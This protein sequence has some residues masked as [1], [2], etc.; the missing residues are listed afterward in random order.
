MDLQLHYL[1]G[2]PTNP[3]EVWELL[4]NQFQKKSWPNVLELRRKLHQIKLE[5]VGSMNKYI[6]EM[7]EIMDEL[8]LIDTPVKKDDRVLYLLASLPD[9]YGMLVTAL[10]ASVAVPGMALVTERLMHEEKKMRAKGGGE[11]KEKEEALASG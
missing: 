6:K 7:T 3:R 9:D 5:E 2:T 8:S 10:S 4:E 11:I 1:L